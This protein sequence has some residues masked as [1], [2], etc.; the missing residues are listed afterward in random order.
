MAFKQKYEKSTF[1]YKSS[2]NKAS[3]FS[4]SSSRS[5]DRNPIEMAPIKEQKYGTVD[6][7]MFKTTDPPN[8]KKPKDD[9][10]DKMTDEQH[11]SHEEKVE[12]YNKEKGNYDKISKNPALI[13][14]ITA[15]G[16]E[17]RVQ[18][19]KLNNQGALNEDEKARLKELRRDYASN[20]RL[21]HNIR[22]K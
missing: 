21:L 22:G 2:P 12:K 7:P 10:S 15:A 11:K 3:Y 1:P 14:K 13:K 6:S 20:Q 8:G 19:D 16:Q 9:D 18:I 17:I 4:F 5:T